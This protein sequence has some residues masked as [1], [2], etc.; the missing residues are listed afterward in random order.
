MCTEVYDRTINTF[1]E[2]DN[3]EW[4]ISWWGQARAYGGCAIDG[5]GGIVVFTTA[6]SNLSIV[7][8]YYG[9]VQYVRNTSIEIIP[10]TTAAAPTAEQRRPRMPIKSA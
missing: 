1:L 9:D 2:L 10:P 3:G 8:Q 7:Q 4:D 5:S 6:Y